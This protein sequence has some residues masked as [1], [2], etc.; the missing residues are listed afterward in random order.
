MDFLYNFSFLTS[1]ISSICS[2][3]VR[4]VRQ[5]IL[6]DMILKYSENWPLFQKDIWK[7]FAV[8]WK[9]GLIS[10]S[11]QTEV[12]WSIGAAVNF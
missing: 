7:F 5:L 8:F 4:M 6:T 1:G 10:T 3:Y 9:T 12:V 11:L 2:A